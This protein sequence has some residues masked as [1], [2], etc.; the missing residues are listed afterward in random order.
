MAASQTGVRGRLVRPVTGDNP[1]PA[2]SRATT[3]NFWIISDKVEALINKEQYE[4]QTT[5]RELSRVLQSLSLSFQVPLQEECAMIKWGNAHSGTY[6]Y[7]SLL[8][9][10]LSLSL[11][12]LD[13]TDNR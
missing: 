10:I 7:K 4:V 5:N 3:H 9:K 11:K 1:D 12:V 6:S 8:I 2:L 13:K